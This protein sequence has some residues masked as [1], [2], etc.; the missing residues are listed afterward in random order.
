MGNE[1]IQYFSVG[2][3]WC[4]FIKMRNENSV[5]KLGMIFFFSQPKSGL[6]HLIFYSFW[7][8]SS[9]WNALRCI[10]INQTLALNACLFCLNIGY[11]QKILKNSPKVQESEICNYLHFLANFEG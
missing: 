3:D 10:E 4:G 5:L 8:F 7:I 1:S 6:E 9:Y 11:P 2:L